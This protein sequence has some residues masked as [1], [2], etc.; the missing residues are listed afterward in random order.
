MKTY[1]SRLH[2]E[3][4][5]GFPDRAV[6]IILAAASFFY[7]IIVRI[8][9]F[10]YDRGVLKQKKLPVFVISIG[11]LTTGGTG[12]TPITGRI[13]SCMTKDYGKKTAV[14]SRGYGGKL[15]V[16]KSNIISDG[17]QIFFDAELA[18]DEPFWIAENSE[19]T[20]VITGRD[21]Y[22]SGK[23]ALN[24]F[25]SEILILDD[26]FQHRKLYRDLNILLI[27]SDKI[28][29]NNHLLPAGPLREPL[30]QIK[31]ADKVVLVNKAPYFKDS[32]EK[33]SGLQKVLKEKYDKESLVCKF[34]ADGIY[35]ITTKQPIQ[36]IQKAVAFSGIAQPESFFGLLQDMRIELAAKRV[37]SDHYIY[38]LEDIK[39]LI[40]GA[41][42][43]RADAVITTEKDS[44]KIRSFMEDLESQIPICAL[45]LKAD[46]DI[47]KL[48]PPTLYCEESA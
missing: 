46:L 47:K 15:A 27:D 18:G 25:N 13:A 48:V 10:L 22:K 45:K 11:N 7:G 5:P 32:E 6:L 17:N 35:D 8:R 33:I 19:G 43:I 28:F 2:Y 40:D 36:R 30:N 21:R 37:F 23:Y 20:V 16:K 44:V 3:K 9:N 24:K 42:T 31:R 26:G 41:Q 1:F 29:G 38:N 39:A 34:I 12:K 14:I 4:T